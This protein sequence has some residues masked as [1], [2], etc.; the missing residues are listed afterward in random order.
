MHKHLVN[1]VKAI[2]ASL[3][4]ISFI[5]IFLG[6]FTTLVIAYYFFQTYA[7]S[8]TVFPKRTFLP[9]FASELLNSTVRK[10]SN[11]HLPCSDVITAHLIT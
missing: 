4:L 2:R 9:N 11:F 8:S 1:C 3:I 7:N 6:G 5:F 10:L